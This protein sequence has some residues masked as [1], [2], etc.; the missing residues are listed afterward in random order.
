MFD[1]FLTTE[2]DIYDCTFSSASGQDAELTRWFVEEIDRVSE[3]IRENIL[4]KAD[5]PL[6]IDQIHKRIW[7][8]VKRADVRERQFKDE[9]KKLQAQEAKEHGGI[10]RWGGVAFNLVESCGKDRNNHC[11]LSQKWRGLSHGSKVGGAYF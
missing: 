1:A 5:I 9:L 11:A 7:R 8:I 6:A 2:P 10:V 4:T 3:R